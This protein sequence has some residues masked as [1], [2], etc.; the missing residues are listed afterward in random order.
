MP[1]R[2]NRNKTKNQ[3]K[4]GKYGEAVISK[5]DGAIN[6]LKN[7]YKVDF[8][9]MILFLHFN[10]MGKNFVFQRI[11]SFPLRQITYKTENKSVEFSAEWKAKGALSYLTPPEALDI[12][13][14]EGGKE[15]GWGEVANF[16]P[17]GKYCY[18]SNF[19]RANEWVP[20]DELDTIKAATDIRVEA[21]K[22]INMYDWG[23]ELIGDIISLLAVNKS[24]AP[25]DFPRTIS[26][27][28]DNL[29]FSFGKMIGKDTL[30]VRWSEQ[31]YEPIRQTISNFDRL[32]FGGDSE[33]EKV[34]ESKVKN[35]GQRCMKNLILED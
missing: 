10:A 21:V 2:R 19:L 29:S 27:D 5:F 9:D 20:F 16:L 8:P 34:P 35:L 28:I 22:S 3:Q 7:R 26:L 6:A 25:D 15:V 12:K 4:L 23:F 11:D 13:A 1:R 33:E 17:R 31:G 30:E 18:G 24:V 14:K 32:L